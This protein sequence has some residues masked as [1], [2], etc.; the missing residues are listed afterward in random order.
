MNVIEQ[1]RTDWNRRAREGANY[2]V[3]FA[4]MTDE[5][6]LG[7]GPTPA[8]VFEREF[9]RLPPASAKDRR[10]LEIGCGPGRLMIPMSRHF[11]EIHGV[12]ISEEMAALA[13]ERLR[14]VPNAHVHV[15]SG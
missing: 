3:A 4:P 10:A 12:D 8:G 7:A 13:R 15:T 9:Y 6:F 2:Y 11:G 1:M 5:E 14:G